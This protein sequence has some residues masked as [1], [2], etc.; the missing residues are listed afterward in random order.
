MCAQVVAHGGDEREPLEAE[1]AA[2]DPSGYEGL[3]LRAVA[4]GLAI[5]TVTTLENIYFALKYGWTVTN[6]ISAAILGYAA[7]SLWS[8]AS[9]APPPTAPETCVLMAAAVAAT[10]MIWGSSLPFAVLAMQAELRDAVGFEGDVDTWA[11]TVP[12]LLAY[13]GALCF[14]GFALAIPLR[15]RYVEDE[16][17]PFPYA[18]AAAKTIESLHGGG[19]DGAPRFLLACAL[20]AAA[21]ATG[22][23]CWSGVERGAAK[24]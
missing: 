9:G 12:R 4:L 19:D 17:L 22:A 20:P 18:V 16:P 2:A 15:R 6:N 7:L 1:G 10:A 13:C 3:T 24:G 21:W 11:P 8:R 23:W 5:G 14:I